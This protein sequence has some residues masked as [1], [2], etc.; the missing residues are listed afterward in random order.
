MHSPARSRS[1]THLVELALLFGIRHAWEDEVVSKL[2]A[3][4]RVLTEVL[5]GIAFPLLLISLVVLPI[6]AVVVAE[7]DRFR[8]QRCGGRSFPLKPSTSTWRTWIVKR[9]RMRSFWRTDVPV[10]LCSLILSAVSLWVSFWGFA[11]G[12]VLIFEPVFWVFGIAAQMGPFIPQSQTQ[13]I[14]AAPAGVLLVATAAGFLVG[15]SLLR[16]VLQ[17]EFS[18]E[19]DPDL[20]A[21][22]EELQSSRA[23]LTRAFELERQRIE[24]D[25]HDGAQQEL[26]AVIMRLGMLETAAASS[27][28]PALA[29]QATQA[30]E[31]AEH[32]LARLRQTVRD[33]HPRELTDLGLSAA[34]GELAARSPLRVDVRSSGNDSFLSAPAAAAAYFTVSEALTNIVKHAGTDRAVVEIDCDHTRVEIRVADDGKGGAEAGS[35]GSGLAGLRERVR[36]V[37][38]KLEIRSPEGGGTIIAAT[39]PCEPPW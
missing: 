6:S 38:G 2:R 16:N 23:S 15:I 39:V 5:A 27:G 30:R 17:R 32:A 31:H 7:I 8:A 35:N 26:V 37:G 29:A 24:R 11:G 19:H 14:L 33:I 22:V 20:V 25:L 34:V 4:R 3:G 13:A 1:F 12:L 18:R 21:K 36:S 28:L 10:Y 9:L